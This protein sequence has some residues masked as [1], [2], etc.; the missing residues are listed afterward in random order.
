MTGLWVSL[1]TKQ[2]T[3]LIID[4]NYSNFRRNLPVWVEDPQFYDFDIYRS[5]SV[6]HSSIFS[7]RQFDFRCSVY[8]Y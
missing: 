8:S 6:V 1:F 2:F 4:N 3:A 7:A 5:K